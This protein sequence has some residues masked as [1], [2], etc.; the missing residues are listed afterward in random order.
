MLSDWQAIAIHCEGRRT[1]RGDLHS[2]SV[3]IIP[4]ILIACRVAFADRQTA[5]QNKNKKSYSSPFSCRCAAFYRCEPFAACTHALGTS[6]LI[7]NV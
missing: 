2:R 1:N 7:F 5:E 4:T 6:C 3:D